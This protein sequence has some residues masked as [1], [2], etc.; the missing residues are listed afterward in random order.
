MSFAKLL[1]PLTGGE[2]D[3]WAIGAALAAAG[4]FK[5]R[6]AALYVRPSPSEALPFMGEGVSGVVIQDIIDAARVAADRGLADA[7]ATLERAAAAAGAVMGPAEAGRLTVSLADAQG[8][9][10]D[11]VADEAVYADLVV[12]GPVTA[13]ETAPRRRSALE[14]AMM[15][16]GRPVLLAPCAP[17]PVIGRN[18]CLAWDGNPAAAHA[19]TAALPFLKAAGRVTLFTIGELE[20][21]DHAGK[22]EAWLATHGLKVETRRVAQGSRSVGEA[23]LAECTAAGGDLLVMGGFGHSRLRQFV[24]GGTTRHVLNNAGLPIFMTH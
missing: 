13:G 3:G 14:A 10:D 11:V 7:R 6:V 8:Y 2:R 16:A 5:A 15:S 9:F 24:L 21:E 12:F 4:L 1:T 20:D 23:L 17:A 19:A 22:A 18:P